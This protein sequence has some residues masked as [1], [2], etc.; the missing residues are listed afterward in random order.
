M[1]QYKILCGEDFVWRR[2]GLNHALGRIPTSARILWCADSAPHFSISRTRLV[3]GYAEL[4]VQESI[5]GTV[6]PCFP[7]SS[8][9]NPVPE[10]GN[11]CQPC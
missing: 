4:A 9:D 5:P 10:T 6:K 8:S 3:S 7:A 1:Q 11:S 2:E